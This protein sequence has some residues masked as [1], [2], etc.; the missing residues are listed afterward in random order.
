[1][2]TGF[3][4]DAGEF[5]RGA[6]AVVV[7]PDTG[8]SSRDAEARLEETAG[9]AMAIGVEVCEKVALRLRQPLL[10]HAGQPGDMLLQF[11]H[12]V[13]CRI[14][15]QFERDLLGHLQV[16]FQVVHRSARQVVRQ[17]LQASQVQPVVEHL[18]VDQGAV[19]LPR[20]AAALPRGTLYLRSH[21]LC[22]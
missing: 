11:G 19:Q 12:I 10:Q 20:Q 6:Q 14:G 15:A 22:P 2:S 5:T 13:A 18:E 16:E 9:L 1:M 3:E 4:R 8:G 17:A 21:R 7:Y